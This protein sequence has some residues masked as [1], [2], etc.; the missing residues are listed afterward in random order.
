MTA[1]DHPMA[2][3]TTCDPLITNA[4]PCPQPPPQAEPQV[5]VGASMTGCGVKAASSAATMWV[6]P[7]AVLE[8]PGS[9]IQE[10]PTAVH[11]GYHDLHI[12]TGL[13]AAGSVKGLLGCHCAAGG[14]PPQKPPLFPLDEC[15][16]CQNFLCHPSIYLCG[17]V[18]GDRA[19]NK[20]HL[21]S[22]STPRQFL[23]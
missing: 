23:L 4:L 5:V 13:M 19:P 2:A 1:R 21:H 16:G 7:I 9:E 12:G 3:L 6:M 14:A 17:S 18:G 10:A 22:H 11:R 15:H 8:G 20:I